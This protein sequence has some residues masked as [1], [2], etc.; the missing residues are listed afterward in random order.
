MAPM[1]TVLTS[2]L[3]A[4]AVVALPA[5]TVDGA[6]S[7]IAARNDPKMF[8]NVQMFAGGPLMRVYGTLAEVYQQCKMANKDFDLEFP[9][10]HNEVKPML[11]TSERSDDD[12]WTSKVRRGTDGHKDR[13]WY[14]Q[15]SRDGP[16]LEI[17]GD[18]QQVYNQARRVNHNFDE[19]FPDFRDQAKPL[20]RK[21]KDRSDN[22]KY[23]KKKSSKGSSSGKVRRGTDGHKDRK[24]YLQISRDGPHLEISGDGQQVYNQARRVNHNFDEE[25]P[26][27]RDQAKPLLRK[28]K[29]R[30]DNDKYTKKKSGK[31][32]SSGKVRRGEQ[33]GAD[34]I[35]TET[36]TDPN[37]KQYWQVLPAKN[38]D[39]LRLYGTLD[40]VHT[41]VL[42]RNPLFDVENIEWQTAI[43]PLGTG[44]IN[45]DAPAPVCQ[46]KESFWWNVQYSKD[47]EFVRLFGTIE[48]VHAQLVLRNPLYEIEFP[49]WKTE[50]KP[51]TNVDEPKAGLQSRATHE[52]N[53][54]RD[55]V[56][57]FQ[58]LVDGPW[59]TLNGTVP[60]MHQKLVEL[61]P[62]FD[63]SY[64]SFDDE[65]TA[66]INDQETYC[67]DTSFPVMYENAWKLQS[68]EDGPFITMFGTANELHNQLV[69]FNPTFD[70]EYPSF[71][72]QM[73]R[74]IDGT[75]E[76]YNTVDVNKVHDDI[77]RIQ[78]FPDG[79]IIKMFGDVDTLHEKLLYFNTDF[80][81]DFP[82]F[83]EQ[84]KSIVENTNFAEHS[85]ISYKIA[86]DGSF[87]IKA[88]E[89]G[90]WINT[91]G[92]IQEIHDQMMEWNYYFDTDFLTFESDMQEI[93]DE[94]VREMSY[95]NIPQTVYKRDV[96]KAFSA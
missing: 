28:G 47:S 78:T 30:S 71:T 34:D 7:I 40:Q 4:S 62:K 96:K 75:T 39:F 21:G 69:Y 44:E 1:R 92:S 57:Q 23:T 10:W 60:E 84:M 86:E 29:D 27:F 77:W 83:K 48:Q 74:I 61:N 42:M 33:N 67:H 13:K 65:M 25:F 76:A 59:V 20:L 81:T 6:N 5:S 24:W 73:S 53:L 54:I 43:I 82:N 90:P 26:D 38:S 31:G 17:S 37:Q 66:L 36:P 12:K 41:Q 93:M 94:H 49:N 87:A 85:K 80:D 89:D 18:G 68:Y 79:P 11:E 3:A 70:S 35:E 22:D 56:W 63:E 88:S 72:E 55:R 52:V 64:P 58:P 14:L 45:P 95:T 8:Y 19:E 46:K 51:I 32:S 50:I 15:I 91:Y 16:H 9:D 2:L